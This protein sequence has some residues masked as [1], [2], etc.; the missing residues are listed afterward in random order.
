M[1]QKASAGTLK[2]KQVKELMIQTHCKFGACEAAWVG[3]GKWIVAAFTF[4]YFSAGWL[5]GWLAGLCE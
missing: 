3:R 2:R 1:G 5:A 4:H